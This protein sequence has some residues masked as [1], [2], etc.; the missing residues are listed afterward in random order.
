MQYATSH[1][2]PIVDRHRGTV[3]AWRVRIHVAVGTATGFDDIDFHVLPN[4]TKP[5]DWRRIDVDRLV[6]GAAPDAK[7]YDPNTMATERRAFAALV[8]LVEDRDR[9]EVLEK[10]EFQE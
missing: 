3:I 10:F 8:R 6:S 9:V 5:Q 7:T 4:E 1:Y 2:R